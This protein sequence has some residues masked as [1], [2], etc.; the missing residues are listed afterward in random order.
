MKHLNQVISGTGEYSDYCL[1]RSAPHDKKFR[2][3]EQEQEDTGR[4]L[5]DDAAV[6][7]QAMKKTQRG[8]G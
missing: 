3:E 4:N 1:S 8:G 7:G 2:Q 5:G 6:D